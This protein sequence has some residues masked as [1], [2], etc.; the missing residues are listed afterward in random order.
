MF[1]FV[2]MSSVPTLR[3]MNRFE[4]NFRIFIIRVTLK[5]NRSNATFSEIF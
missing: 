1:H 5:I 2:M 3:P 4:K